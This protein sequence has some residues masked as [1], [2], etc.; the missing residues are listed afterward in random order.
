MKLPSLA[1]CVIA[2]NEEENM[3]RCLASVRSLADEIIVVD[4]GS[5][6]ATPVIA[7]S[8]GARVVSSAWEMD[9]SRARNEALEQVR[10]GWV[11]M[12][13]A[14]EQ[15]TD[16]DPADLKSKLTGAPDGMDAFSVRIDNLLDGGGAASFRAVRLF[17]SH[18]DIRYRGVIHEDVTR[19]LMERNGRPVCP[20]QAPLTLTHWGY[21]RGER[22]RQNKARRNLKLLE[23]AVG[24]DPR[25]ALM[26]F[27]LARELLIVSGERIFPGDRFQEAV[28]NLL[29]AREAAVAE[30]VPEHLRCGILATLAAAY[31]A[32]ARPDRALEV[33]GI[34][35]QR[36]AS[37]DVLP[38]G[39]SSGC[40]KNLPEKVDPASPSGVALAFARGR[41]WLAAAGEDKD[42]LRLAAR[43]LGDL[44]ERRPAVGFLDLDSRVTGIFAMERQAEALGRLGEKK[45]AMVLLKTAAD[46]ADSYAGPLIRQAELHLLE[47]EVQQGFKA[48]ADALGRDDHD[49][50]AWLGTAR[51]LNVLGERNQASD[52]V[53]HALSLVPL[54]GQALVEQAVTRFLQ[55]DAGM[56][57]E[58]QSRLRLASPEADVVCLLAEALDG[59]PLTGIRPWPN[60]SVARAMMSVTQGLVSGGRPDLLRRLQEV[61]PN[62]GEGQGAAVAGNG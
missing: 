54:W 58:E 39:A 56:L 41:A 62:P 11:L 1:V 7:E 48:Y 59:R 17:R 24:A 60:R 4:T 43:L 14:D 61:L 9:F 26:R 20:G 29:K 37:G 35:F 47:G 19:S 28:E 8:M 10:S 2:R 12:V 44:Q 21:L 53:G 45:R 22:V 3:E 23:R 38:P 33:L 15:V 32:D 16:C 55:G 18:K 31:T 49:P 40:S 25:Q 50:E 30:G 51:L 34:S 5:I 6:D 36:P 57:L 27:M 52:C 46:L 13:D 42:K